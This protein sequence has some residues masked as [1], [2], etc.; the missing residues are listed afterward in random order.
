MIQEI[1]VTLAFLIVFY[2]I[3]HIIRFITKTS[4]CARCSALLLTM[5]VLLLFE[6]G[7]MFILLMGFLLSTLAYYTDDYIMNKKKINILAQDFIIMLVFV[8]IGMVIIWIL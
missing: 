2:I 6:Y 3:S 7:V 1:M 8:L 4:F 5:L